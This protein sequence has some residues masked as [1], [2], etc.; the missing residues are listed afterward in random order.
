MYVC[1]NLQIT[2]V[3]YVYIQNLIFLQY[4]VFMFIWHYKINMFD[5]IKTPI[6]SFFFVFLEMV[7]SQHI[8]PSRHQTDESALQEYQSFIC[9]E[10]GMR[11]LSLIELKEH[12][13]LKHSCVAF[14]MTCR[15]PFKSNQGYVYHMSMHEGGRSCDICGKVVQS[16]T[17]LKRHKLTHSDHKSFACPLCR[18][19]FKH[20]YHMKTHMKICKFPCDTY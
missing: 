7:K 3:D 11:P 17:H 19:R 5:I 14:C 15:K 16:E 18:K 20:K 13:E 9:M 12:Y 2:K 8:F 1:W 6:S 4:L 10:C